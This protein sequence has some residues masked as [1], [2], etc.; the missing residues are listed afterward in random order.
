MHAVAPAYVNS[1]QQPQAQVHAV[2]S[3]QYVPPAVPSAQ[4]MPPAYYAADGVHGTSA[5]RGQ[6]VEVGQL[7]LGSFPAPASTGGATGVLTAASSQHPQAQAHVP[8]AQHV[9]E[10]QGISRNDARV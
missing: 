10:T 7:M 9:P 5:A 8:V 2:T 6:V 4:Y 1:M 3:A